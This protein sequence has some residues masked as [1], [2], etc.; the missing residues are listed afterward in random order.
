MALDFLPGN[1]LQLL[2]AGLTADH[3]DM[4]ATCTACSHQWFYSYRADG[5]RT[6]RM[7]AV[8]ALNKY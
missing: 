1:R 3:I 6:G 5:G 4:A 8:I 2:E 7:A